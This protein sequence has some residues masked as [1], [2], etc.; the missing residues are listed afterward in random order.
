MEDDPIDDSLSPVAP[1]DPIS[2]Y[3]TDHDRTLYL[4]VLVHVHVILILLNFE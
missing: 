3:V 1:A 4:C 2:K